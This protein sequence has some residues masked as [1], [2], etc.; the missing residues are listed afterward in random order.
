M[1]TR[2]IQLIGAASP[3]AVGPAVAQPT[4]APP[5]PP[6]ATIAFID[7]TADLG[8][9][10]IDA[11]R[12]C[13]ADLN[14]DGWPDLMVRTK[15]RYRLFLHVLDAAKPR[16]YS[17]VEVSRDTGLPVPAGG[18]CLVFADL[19]ND[20]IA[21]A[22]LIRS[23]DVNN[24]DFKPP[25]DQPVESAWLKGNGDGT[26]AAPHV[27]G[28]K[29]ATS[30]CVAVGD[31]DRDGRLDLY[32]GNWYT[33]YGKSNEA[34][35]N[36]LLLQARD[37]AGVFRRISLPEDNEMFDESSDRA[38][39]P[40]YGALIAQ[41]GDLTLSGSNLPRD[42]QLI[43][44]N[45]GR[46]ANRVWTPQ[47]PKDPAGPAWHDLAPDLG[48][49]GDLV[50]HG[51]YPAWLKERAKT[52]PR[53]DRPDELPYRSHGNSFDAAVADI[54]NDGLFDL[55]LA[56]IAHA[57]AG[58]SSDRSRVLIQSRGPDNAAVFSSPSAASI[59]RFPQP[60]DPLPDD[61]RPNWNQGDLFVELA[62][63][64]H[65]GL[66]DLI[67]SSGDYPDPPPHDNRLR[68]F[69]QQPGGS[70]QD[71][72]ADSG[73]DHVGS[74]QLSLADVDADGDIDILVGQS[75]N[76]FPKPLVDSTNQRQHS[77]GPR[78]RLFLNQASQSHP[79][80]SITISLIGHPLHQIAYDPLG[81]VV[82]LTLTRPDGSRLT[83]SRQLIGIGGHAGKQ[84]QFLVHFGLAGADHADSLEVVWPTSDPL[85]TT[86]N[87]PARLK[88]DHYIMRATRDKP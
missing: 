20:S 81:A 48:L 43:E 21:D 74:A 57:W 88:P 4:A 6:A 17:F 80:S 60:L 44:L 39:R 64:D 84:N 53:F 2:I 62:D 32:I 24:P 35:T 26:F 40:T 14:A 10:S 75:Y 9:D 56:E 8:L 30:A 72:T 13:F 77:Q 54:N 38:G 12:L 41:L 50:R 1:R 7:A 79:A 29:K 87:D 34:F 59:D 28:S 5:G 25:A 66:T 85:V 23:L 22:I 83:Q 52:D 68:I 46:R 49:D 15:D 45:Y 63:L 16:G 31:V 71:V 51:K 78:L 69:R 36:D 86:I 33:Q 76:R 3:L 67:L 55:A 70:F 11:T 19:D 42:P 37:Q 65:D 47:V 82:R 61:F 27:L 58:D 73:I 18:D